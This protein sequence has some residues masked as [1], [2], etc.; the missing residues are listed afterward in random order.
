M[1]S[2]LILDS[3]HSGR[4]AR[5]SS[6]PSVSIPRPVGIARA[7]A[8]HTYGCGA[9]LTLVRTARLLY[10]G[11]SMSNMVLPETKAVV[12]RGTESSSPVPSSYLTVCIGPCGT[13]TLY[14]VVTRGGLYS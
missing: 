8:I 4:S 5:G 3:S 6:S 13:V 12:P 7:G 9:Y 14:S 2:V 11:G 10:A 1:G